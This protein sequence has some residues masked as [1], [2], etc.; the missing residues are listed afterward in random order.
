MPVRAAECLTFPFTSMELVGQLQDNRTESSAAL[1]LDRVERTDNL[2]VHACEIC[3]A[4][5]RLF[6]DRRR[7]AKQNRAQKNQNAL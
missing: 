3:I 1:W 4:K 6:V 7:P 2:H 5:P